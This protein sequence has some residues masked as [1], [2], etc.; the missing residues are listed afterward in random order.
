[1]LFSSFKYK[2]I[3]NLETSAIAFGLIFLV[4]VQPT[5]AHHPFDG[6]TPASFVEGFLSGLGHPIVGLDHF[7]FVIAVGLLAVFRKKSGMMHRF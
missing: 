1:M 7:A 4:M 2:A 3:A 6:R 5:L